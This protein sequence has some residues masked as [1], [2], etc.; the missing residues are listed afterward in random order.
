MS[1][2]RDAYT[3]IPHA[4]RDNPGTY[5]ELRNK[6]EIMARMAFQIYEKQKSYQKEYDLLLAKCNKLEEDLAQARRD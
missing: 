1:E 3:S 2:D 4:N 5:K 6:V